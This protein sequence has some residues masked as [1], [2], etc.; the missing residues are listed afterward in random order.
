LEREVAERNGFGPGSGPGS[1]PVSS[2]PDGPADGAAGGGGLDF[3]R[4]RR[5]ALF[6][7]LADPSLRTLLA[8]AW[9]RRVDDRAQLFVQGD[10]ADRFYVLL[11]GWVKLYRLTEDGAEALV[12]VVAPARP[13]PR[14]R[15]S[16]RRA[17][18]CVPRRW[19]QHRR[20]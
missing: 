20:W 15:C 11:D 4:L 17:F 16:P 18:R 12:T 10:E 5:I 14:R 8:D 1:G 13:S 2:S 6:Q 7:G 9:V 19:E 3:D